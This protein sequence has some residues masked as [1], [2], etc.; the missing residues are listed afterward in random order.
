MTFFEIN[1]LTDATQS[2]SPSAGAWDVTTESKAF[3]IREA[4]ANITTQCPASTIVVDDRFKQTENCPWSNSRVK[5]KRVIFQEDWKLKFVYIFHLEC[6]RLDSL[7]CCRWGS[8]RF[9]MKQMGKVWWRT[10]AAWQR[11][12]ASLSGSW[13]VN[14]R[15]NRKEVAFKG[16]QRFLSTSCLSA[17]EENM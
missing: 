15:Q 17:M 13:P 12:A 8:E 9:P 14:A 16:S 5:E 7:K 1:W 10:R 3:R 6:R 2:V 4:S 11:P